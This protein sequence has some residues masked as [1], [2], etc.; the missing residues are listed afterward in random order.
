MS[1]FKYVIGI[2]F[3]T[4]SVRSVIVDVSNGE[5]IS[6]NISYFKRWAEGLYCNPDK[7]Q[8]RQHPLDHFESLEESVA[9]VLK[10]VPT[11]IKNN[12]MGIGVDTTGST[13]GPL[14]KNGMT[15]A[16]K[17]EFSDNPNAMFVMWKDHSPVEEAD[18]INKIAKSWGGENY[19]KFEGG[20][21]SSE[22]FWSK[23]LHVS[24]KD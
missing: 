6:Y 17:K 1:K 21:Y 7:N 18:L 3:G 9:G 10:K 5:E 2:D 13:V 11:D 16:L 19:T 8:F 15:L 12:V 14:D 20:V 4:D 24:K 23:I 22:W